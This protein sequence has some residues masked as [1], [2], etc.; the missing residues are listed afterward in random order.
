MAGRAVVE[1]LGAEGEAGDAINAVG[2]FAA[3]VVVEGSR[4][5][6]L[7]DGVERVTSA[8]LVA[9]YARVAAAYV[10]PPHGCVR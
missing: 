7:N 10:A 4:A 5:V 6:R 2:A 8:A 1:A 9:K 3:D